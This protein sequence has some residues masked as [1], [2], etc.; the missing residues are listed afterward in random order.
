MKPIAALLAAP[1]LVL[2]SLTSACL[3]EHGFDYVGFDLFSKPAKT[4]EDCCNICNT[5]YACKAFTWSG[6]DG[7]TCYLKS[8]R[9]EIV[10]SPY[11]KS[12]LASFGTVLPTCELRENS[13]FEGMDIGQQRSPDAKNC[14]KIC[15]DF[16]GCRAYSWSG[17][18]GG[19][20]FL[21][22]KVVAR[23]TR[24]GVSSAWAYPTFG[25]DAP[26]S[27]CKLDNDVDIVG[28]DIGSASSPSADICCAWC[29]EQPG[30]HAF[31][32]NDY[33][34]GTCWFKSGPGKRVKAPGTVSSVVHSSFEG[35]CVNVA[36]VDFA[37]NDLT[38]VKASKYDECCDMCTEDYDNGGGCRAYTWT[39][40]ENGTC[41][42]K[43]SHDGRTSGH[44]ISGFLIG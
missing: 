15:Q 7:G 37:G 6:Y 5:E 44:G 32:W 27:H 16:D 39:E 3:I 42:L 20:C 31:S 43:S 4:A 2:P 19:T 9:G 25:D 14:C 1:T 12:G 22:G 40:Y 36:G 21:K 34:G 35:K 24:P 11:T 23:V 33:N 10:A 29:G 38:S 26:V 18:N 17:Y 28:N 13:D 41:W 30:C 8:G